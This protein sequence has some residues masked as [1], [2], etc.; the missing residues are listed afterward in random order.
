MSLPEWVDTDK[1]EWSSISALPTAVP[2]LAEHPDKVVPLYLNY[3]T[4]PDAIP[5]LAGDIEVTSLL[6]HRANHIMWN[7]VFIP[8]NEEVILKY[9]RDTDKISENPYAVDFL[10]KYPGYINWDSLRF[11]PNPSVIHLFSERPEYQ[12]INLYDY[13]SS[14]THPDAIP[15]LINNSL[16]PWR[17][18]VFN[19]HP[20]VLDWLK[21]NEKWK[22]LTCK[23][24]NPDVIRWLLDSHYNRHE[25]YYDKRLHMLSSNPVATPFLI[26][27]PELVTDAILDNPHPGAIDL[28]ETYINTLSDEDRLPDNRLC[29]TPSKRLSKNPTAFVL[30]EK[31][32]EL[33]CYKSLSTNPSLFR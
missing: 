33:I 16:R 25:S 21:E 18:L 5:L 22:Y 13:V 12:S 29:Y 23:N 14:F 9:L 20:I 26:E 8:K 28:I 19:P 27:H 4:N 11:N 3:N 7:Q 31:Y 17:S 24:R 30:L 2:Y 10:K 32:P 6:G 1:L 15:Y